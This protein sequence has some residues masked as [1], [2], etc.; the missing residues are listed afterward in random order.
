MRLRHR[1]SAIALCAVVAA[2]GLFALPEVAT[3]GPI[4]LNPGYGYAQVH[5]YQPIGQSV[6]AEDSF[7]TAALHF[8]V[9]NP[10][11]S[12]DD[13]IRYDLYEGFGTGGALLASRQ[14]VL[15]PGFRDSYDVDFSSVTLRVGMEY[16]LVA[17]V[18]G[19]SA[20]W[21]VYGSSDSYAGGSPI[22]GRNSYFLPEIALRVLPTTA[23]VPDSGPSLLLLGMGLAGLRAWR[24]RREWSTPRS[25]SMA[26]GHHRGGP[27]RVRRDSVASGAA[28]PPRL[29]RASATGVD[30]TGTRHHVRDRA[31]E[32]AV[33]P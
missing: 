2:A 7:V 30:M 28:C 5:Y 18:V 17:S 13:P 6:T 22:L 10:H 9:I 25:A 11:F 14:F 19:D 21:A 32:R 12:P 27:R 8:S 4:V 29:G 23:S 20:Y 1:A 3:A 15:T 26:G 31:V 33:E 16:S 24:K